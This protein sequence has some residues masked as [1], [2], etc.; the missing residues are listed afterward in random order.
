[1]AINANVSAL[2]LEAEN[3]DVQILHVRHQRRYLC[4]LEMN[5]GVEVVA[6]LE[7]VPLYPAGAIITVLDLLREESEVHHPLSC[8][9]CH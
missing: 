8:R 6:D 2:K 3:L 1:M 9:G 4:N 5:G 7:S